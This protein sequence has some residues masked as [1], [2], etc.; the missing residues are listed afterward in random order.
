MPR[1]KLEN[2]FEMF[3]SGQWSSLVADARMMSEAASTARVR[4]R[5]RQGDGRAVRAEKL[6]MMGE[7]SSARQALESTGVAPGDQNTLNALRSPERRPRAP[8]APLPP[9][10]RAMVPDRKFELDEECF[11]RNLRSGRRGA[12]PGPSGMTC[13]HL[14]LLLESERESNLLHQVADLI[15]TGQVP[16]MALQTMRLG[17]LTAL[18]KPDGGVRGIVVSDVL[19][20]LV[21]RTIAKQCCSS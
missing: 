10:L 13:E 21:A 19:R 12:A 11:C 17:R 7:L 6:A 1:R 16:P 3:F 9:E 4:K 8:R 18:K 5:R 2:R 15:A 20:R 14:Q